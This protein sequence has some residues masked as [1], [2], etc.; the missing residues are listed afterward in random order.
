MAL[1]KML[2]C[3]SEDEVEHARNEAVTLFGREACCYFVSCV[4]HNPDPETF[5][6]CC[7]PVRQA[8]FDTI[9]TI[10]NSFTGEGFIANC[11]GME[12]RDELLS[13]GYLPIC[14]PACEPQ[15]SAWKNAI[16]AQI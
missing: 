3:V 12:P 14:D 4:K 9:Q 7:L 11:T 5:F 6:V 15:R 10:R 1:V 2:V 16:R 13:R 8:V